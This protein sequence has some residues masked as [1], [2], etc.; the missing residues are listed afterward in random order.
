MTAENVLTMFNESK[1]KNEKGLNNP[2]NSAFFF[3]FVIGLE[4]Q[5]QLDASLLPTITT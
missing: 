5:L 3:H 4:G 2:P 1:E